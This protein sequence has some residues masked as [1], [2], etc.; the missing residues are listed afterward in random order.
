[1]NR[2]AQ[3][4]RRAEQRLDRML[5]TTTAQGHNV[6]LAWG[7]TPLPAGADTW[8]RRTSRVTTERGVTARAREADA[9][10]DAHNR[11]MAAKRRLGLDVRTDEHEERHG[12]LGVCKA[13]LVRA[14]E[15]ARDPRGEL[16][17]A[18][19]GG[20]EYAAWQADGL[21]VGWREQ[22]GEVAV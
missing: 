13:T 22:S 20:D 2:A 19:R 11:R 4:Q 6:D 18:A 8:N 14:A 1:M 12:I 7:Q 9:W 3:K 21:F 17:A 15:D 5:S 10:Q 16:L